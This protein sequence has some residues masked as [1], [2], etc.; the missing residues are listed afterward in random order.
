[1]TLNLFTFLMQ[2]GKGGNHTQTH[3]R[4]HLTLSQPLSTAWWARRAKREGNLRGHGVVS[5][6]ECSKRLIV[7]AAPLHFPCSSLSQHIVTPCRGSWWD[8]NASKLSFL[9]LVQL[10]TRIKKQR[11]S[12]RHH[13]KRAT[14][15]LKYSFACLN[16]ARKRWGSRVITLWIRPWIYCTKDPWKRARTDRREGRYSVYHALPSF[17]VRNAVGLSICIYLYRFDFVS[18]SFR[19]RF[20]IFFD[21]R[22]QGLP[23]IILFRLILGTSISTL[24]CKPIA[25]GDKKKVAAAIERWQLILFVC[26]HG[27]SM[28]WSSRLQRERLLLLSLLIIF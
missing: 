6:P 2:Y 13:L 28:D 14:F 22:S 25:V 17:E 26:F 9:W 5:K 19:F 23:V 21:G 10:T 16:R 12:S 24:H 15:I 20:D 18:I 7:C 8:S 4:T 1:M 3:S 27:V 11:V